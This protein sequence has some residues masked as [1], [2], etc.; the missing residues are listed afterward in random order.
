MNAKESNSFPPFLCIDADEFDPE[1]LNRAVETNEFED[2][3]MAAG[4]SIA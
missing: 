4:A 2:V 1:E 3:P